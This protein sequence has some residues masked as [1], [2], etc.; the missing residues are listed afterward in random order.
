MALNIKNLLRLLQE[1]FADIETCESPVS[2][3]ERAAVDQIA[4]VIRSYST[5]DVEVEDL[6]DMDECMNFSGLVLFCPVFS[7]F[8]QFRSFLSMYISLVSGSSR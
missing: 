7:S 5:G 6:L 2:E 8:R 4:E 1:K 3:L